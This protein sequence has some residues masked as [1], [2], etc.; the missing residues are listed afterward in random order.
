MNILKNL[1]KPNFAVF[2][3]ALILFVSCNQYDINNETNE[4]KFDYS[5]YNSF[6]G[7]FLVKNFNKKSSLQEILKSINKAYQTN[8]KLPNDIEFNA[9]SSENITSQLINKGYLTQQSLNLTNLFMEKLQQT[10]F[11]TAISTF[12][13]EVLNLQISD[14]E[15]IKYNNTINVIKILNK[16]DKSLFD[17]SNSGE[18][19]SI[20]AKGT[21]FWCTVMVVRLG[22]S[23]A[24]LGLCAT[25]IACAGAIANLAFAL[26]AVD[27]ECGEK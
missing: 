25:V 12:E 17:I 20:A 21:S 9:K 1:R 26:R 2:L 11:D 5:A 8:I 4:R 19:V 24:A 22:A 6:D 16:S 27:S 3:S 7:Q 23:V 10:D 18:K 14:E 13:N 15:F